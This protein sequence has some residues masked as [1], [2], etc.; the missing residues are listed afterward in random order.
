MPPL[1]HSLKAQGSCLHK[2]SQTTAAVAGPDL[3]HKPSQT[4]AAVAGPNCC[5]PS[6]LLQAH[7][8]LQAQTCYIN[9]A[10]QLLLLQAHLL[11]QAQAAVAG[12]TAVAGPNLPLHS[13]KNKKHC[14]QNPNSKT[15]SII[16]LL[17]AVRASHCTKHGLWIV[18]CF[19][20]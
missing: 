20:T 9:S 10:K 12:P 18:T 17:L 16:Q 8:L 5:R 6:L 11:L 19:C 4:T 14:I 13:L 15:N 3:L 2:P 7:L 1:L